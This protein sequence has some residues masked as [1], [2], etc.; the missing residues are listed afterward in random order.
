MS[1]A[2]YL[3]QTNAMM[4]ELKTLRAANKSQADH[5][6]LLKKQYDDLAADH[7]AMLQD[8]R[9]KLHRAYTERDR[10]E[11][12]ASEIKIVLDTAAEAILQGIRAL[13]GDEQRPAAAP[14]IGPDASEG[15][16]RLASI[17]T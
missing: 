4:R 16:R 17:G 7:D 12:A 2:I 10:A 14:Q 6:G 5:I 9:A 3:E 13:K 11:R 8:F 1:D 15:T